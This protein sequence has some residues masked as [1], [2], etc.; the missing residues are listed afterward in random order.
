MSTNPQ[1]FQNHAKLVPMFHFVL[2]PLLLV[3]FLAVAYGAWQRPDWST[4][5]AVV[6]AFAFIV[7]AFFARTFAL[8]AQD[9]LIRL[10]E[11]LRMRELLP[12][13]L[14]GRISDFS[15]EQ[16]IGLRFASNAEL[17][18]LAATVLRDNIQ[19]RKVI[20]AMVKDWRADMLRV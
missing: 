4:G 20:K 18:G 5:W 2:L 17:P 7:M 19:Q 6:M 9:R 12:Q 3:N 1:S 14:Q 13:E 10:E 16:L 11:R 15:P 8:T